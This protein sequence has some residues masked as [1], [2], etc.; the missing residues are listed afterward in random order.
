MQTLSKDSRLWE[1]YSEDADDKRLI[2]IYFEMININL[3]TQRN[4]LYT[5]IN[6]PKENRSTYLPKHIFG[7]YYLE[8]KYVVWK[9][10][11]LWN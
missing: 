4:V 6:D 8:W 2:Y 1:P 5:C 9:L 11:T 3:I 7:H 10:P